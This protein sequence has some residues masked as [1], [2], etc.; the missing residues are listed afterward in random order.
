M[1]AL[2]ASRRLAVL[3]LGTALGLHGAR[4]EEIV[5]AVGA[6][7]GGPVGR[8]TSGR[9][10]TLAPGADVFFKD[11][12]STRRGGS[13]QLVFLD[14]STL[15]IG[16]NSD[17]VIDE[18]VYR[19]GGGGAMKARLTRGILRFVG[20]EIS[21][22]GGTTIAT[23]VVTIGIRGGIGTIGY[24]TSAQAA[25]GVPGVP[26][27]FHGGTVVVNGY[28][29]LTVRNGASEVTITRP[30]FGV[31]VGGAH[32]TIGAPVAIDAATTQA[33]MRAATSR[34][35]QR[36]GLSPQAAHVAGAS[37]AHLPAMTPPAPPA[38]LVTPA[39]NALDF[40]A[41]VSLSNSVARVRAQ[42]HQAVQAVQQLHIATPTA[43]ATGPSTGPSGAGGTSSSGPASGS[44]SGASSSGGVPLGTG[45]APSGGG[46]P[47]SGTGGAPSGGGPPSSGTGGAPP[48]GHTPPG[49]GGGGP[50]QPPPGPPAGG[51]DNGI[52]NGG[53]NN[54]V[55]N[56][57][58]GIGNLVGGLLG[59][60]KGG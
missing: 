51:H 59:K 52:G 9:M 24:L 13:A 32:E 5:G 47:S 1:T 30:G 25:A 42:G 60:G 6:A 53:H 33:L 3:L 28:G 11:R 49:P 55:G 2:R 17:V 43:T 23:P 19:P 56:L 20:G 15:N 29:A 45:G 36:G 34:A 12:I 7:N 10:R 58:D 27:G 35:G 37:L 16:E 31:F 39:V 44:G 41:I 14:R 8:T 26:A 54:G 57:V 40:T 48:G 18:F 21:H 46:A 22:E 50:P 38:P 4:G